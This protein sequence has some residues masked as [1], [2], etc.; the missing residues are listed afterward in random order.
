MVVIS[1][2]VMFTGVVVNLHYRT[3][4]THIMSDTARLVYHFIRV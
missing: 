4:D 2:S 1:A 3:P